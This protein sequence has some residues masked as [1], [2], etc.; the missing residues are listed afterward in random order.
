MNNKVINEPIG[1]ALWG[2]GKHAIKNVLPALSKCDNF[3]LIGIHTRNK[4]ELTKQA[5]YWSCK[6][7]EYPDQMLSDSEVQA[8][9]ISTP[10]GIHYNN[11]ISSLKAKKHVLCEKPMTINYNETN[12]LINFA[13][14]QDLILMECNAFGYHPQFKVISEIVRNN[15]LGKLK[16]FSS[17]FG[18]PHLK[19]DD[20]RYVPELGGGALFDTGFYPVSFAIHLMNQPPNSVVGNLQFCEDYKV[21]TSGNAIL[22][23]NNGVQAFAE[24]GFGMYYRN[25]ATLWGSEGI[26]RIMHAFSK[27]D[28]LET[29]IILETKK[30]IEHKKIKASN[31]F[32]LML[33]HFAADIYDS[34]NVQNSSMKTLA[35][36]TTMGKILSSG[37]R[38]N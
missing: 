5:E 36:A 15:H 16:L 24:W 18:I 37:K 13:H 1:I 11:V 21:D 25:E 2:L 14:N 8:I 35:I 38:N 9:Y 22:K 33:N 30:G 31:H 28:N 12:K 10:T 4:S 29:E 27:P 3:N 34:V 32:I 23:F 6:A 7:Y 26:A 20:F 17:Q 19:N